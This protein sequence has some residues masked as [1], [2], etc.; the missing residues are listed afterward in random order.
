MPS[1][2]SRYVVG[3]V[4]VAVICFFGYFGINV[5]LSQTEN[6]Q[7]EEALAGQMPL[8]KQKAA[9]SA[10]AYFDEQWGS[11][12][13]LLEATVYFNTDKHMNGYV[14]KNDLADVYTKPLSEW[15]PAD[16][17]Q[18]AVTRDGQEAAVL[19]LHMYSGEVFGWESSEPMTGKP[20]DITGLLEEK[21]FA[22]ADL[23]E[24]EMQPDGKTLYVYR[25]P[26]ERVG[27]AEL[28]FRVAVLDGAV[29]SFQPYFDVPA[30][31][32]QWQQE[33][34][35]TSTALQ[36]VS[37]ASSFILAVVAFILVIVYRRSLTFTR[38]IVLTLAYLATA[39]MYNVNLVPAYEISG[40]GSAT[41]LVWFQGVYFF[42]SA[43]TVYLSGVSGEGLWRMEGRQLWPRF[44]EEGF[45]IHVARSMGLGYLFCFV[46]MGLQNTL[47]LFGYKFLDIWAIQ[48]AMMSPYNLQW[49]YLFPLLAWVA[50]ISEELIYRVFGLAVFKKLVRY[51]PLAALLS[52]MVWGL[53]HVGYPIY[54]VYT[55]FVEVTILGLLF[56][57]IYLRHGF[58]TALFTHAIMD[59]VLMSFS[60]IPVGGL[61]NGLA[62]VFFICFPAIV[63]GLLYLL[64]RWFRRAPRTA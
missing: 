51:T 38:S 23:L 56:C 8:S 45:G 32:M 34:D 39:L 41:Y 37:M 64:H 22:N 16:Y 42:F 11:G 61:M 55:R 10:L 9:D 63:G 29:V 52:S 40:A 60:I 27:E 26:D 33:Q 24:Q 17:F 43:F 1:V 58:Y 44:G 20:R 21:G 15:A 35:A 59:S 5:Y 54:P 62:A 25:L 30:S 53:G 48:D 14:Q 50:A 31:Y 3:L 49:A 6:L 2:T 36:L 12:H 13:G 47:F 7:T 57:Y 28:R 18:V 46:V 19:Y 4:I